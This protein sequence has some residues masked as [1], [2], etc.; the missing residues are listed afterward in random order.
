MLFWGCFCIVGSCQGVP[1]E[2]LGLSFFACSFPSS[3]SA[4]AAALCCVWS[5]ALWTSR[6][7]LWGWVGIF[8]HTDGVPYAVPSAGGKHSVTDKPHVQAYAYKTPPPQ[9][10]MQQPERGCFSKPG[11][12]NNP[13][14]LFR[15]EFNQCIIPPSFWNQC[16]AVPPA[17]GRSWTH[18][19]SALEFNGEPQ[20]HAGRPVSRR[21]TIQ[22]W[23]KT[24]QAVWWQ[25]AY[26]KGGRRETV[27]FQ[28]LLLFRQGFY[29]LYP[30]IKLSNSTFK[31]S[32][33]LKS[34]YICSGGGK[35]FVCV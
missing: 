16:C 27:V 4:L 20:G 35:G 1:G 34:F 15:L 32:R 5:S 14:W 22:C 19:I 8:S 12:E 29:S 10:G 2:E 3:C 24:V 33:C 17:A 31:Q 11:W 18:L 9:L 21:L 28:L 26:Q 25:K 30:W 13:N 6:Q 7:L 23:I